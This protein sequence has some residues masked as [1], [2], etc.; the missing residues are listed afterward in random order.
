MG[1]MRQKNI[2]HDMTLGLRKIWNNLFDLLEGVLL[3]DQELDWLSLKLLESGVEMDSEEIKRQV[4]QNVL[5]V[6]LAEGI[7]EQSKTIIFSAEQVRVFFEISDSYSES[8]DYMLPFSDVF[9]QFSEGVETEVSLGG[10]SRLMGLLLSQKEVD[11]ESRD[12]ANAEIAKMGRS[13]GIDTD[14]APSG[15]QG[16]LKVNHCFAIYD[17]WGAFPFSWEYNTDGTELFIPYDRLGQE[18]YQRYRNL[19]IAC[20][21]YINCENIYLHKEGEVP[22]AVNRKRA[23]QGKK[24]LEP[25]YTC[26]IRGVQYDSNGE[27]TGEGTHHGFRYDV[28]GHFRK[29][30]TGKT[31]WVRPHQRGLQN[32]LYIPKTYVVE[33]GAKVMA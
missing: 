29:L 32:E 3:D 15:L 1:S 19:A 28:R 10:S 7:S 16:K 18:G 33:K 17:N 21:G 2:R 23:K 27:P 6:R 5:D 14:Y 9:V 4:H 22:D 24:I 26:R 8:L 31:T 13:I 20:I 30:T 11:V 12:L 25:Y